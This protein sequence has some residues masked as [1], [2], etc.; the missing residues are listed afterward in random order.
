MGNK[1]TVHMYTVLF[2]FL[3]M[4][5]LTKL[6]VAHPITVSDGRLVREESSGK[7]GEGSGHGLVSGTSL[8]ESV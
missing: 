3:F 2:I 4:V 6:L 5:H 1:T 7:Q 8:L